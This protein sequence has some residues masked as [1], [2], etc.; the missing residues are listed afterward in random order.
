MIFD[1]DGVC[2][3]GLVSHLV[4]NVLEEFSSLALSS[5]DD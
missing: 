5:S 3:Y 1:G 2:T 4:P